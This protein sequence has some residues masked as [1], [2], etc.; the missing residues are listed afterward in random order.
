MARVVPNKQQGKGS[1]IASMAG[2]Q[3]S[4]KVYAEAVSRRACSISSPKILNTALS[5][6]H[7]E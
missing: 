1:A 7:T 3:F 2:G 6:R 5:T 4:S